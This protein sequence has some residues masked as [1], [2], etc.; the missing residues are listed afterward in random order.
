[1]L[2]QLVLVDDE[3]WILS[4]L[5]NA[6]QWEEIGFCVAGAYTNG[7]DAVRAM[8]E[9]PPDAVLTDIKMP[10]Q[11]GISMVRELREAGLKEMEVVFLSGYD[12]FELA[13]SSVRLGAVDY[14]LKPSAP[15]QI[16]EVFQRIR[17]RLDERRKK[18]V[19][20]RTASE[21]AQAGIKVFKDGV[22]NSI[23]N[24]N[25]Q[26]YSRLM[27]QYSEF[28]ERERGKRFVLASAALESTVEE[29]R[30]D[31]DEAEAICCFQ[32]EAEAL[33]QGYPGEMDILKNQFS[34][35]LCLHD[36][37]REEA[38][39]LAEELR[40]RLRRQTGKK[41]L[42]GLSDC[43]DQLEQIQEA[44]QAS[45]KRLFGLDMA[46]EP[47]ALYLSMGNDTVLKAA[48]E[49]RD[50]QIAMWSLK[51]WFVRIDRMEEG[52]RRRLLGR[53]VYS[54]SIFF[55][56]N[57]F[58]ERAVEQL[59]QAL[60]R[61][62]C[63]EIKEGVISV[64]KAELLPEPG[65]NT[66]N[67]HLCREVAKFISRNYADEITLSGLA[68]QFYISPNYLG[69][70]FRKNMGVGVKEYQA[71]VRL[72]QADV[73][74]SSGKFKLYQ[75]AEMVGYPNYEYFRKTYYK[76]RGKNPSA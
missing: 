51:N 46:A 31:R 45:L 76:Y 69:T 20:S 63:E 7:K 12:D 36:C 21:L 19:E 23:V 9:N 18:A 30:P 3:D 70:L 55:L 53:L 64:I 49:D 48:V 8:L 57:S 34:I 75:V 74:I 67:A 35:S 62:S 40:R 28:V 24:G 65:E 4:G 17:E 59:Y 43:C 52:C 66:R 29:R 37:G 16:I 5:E 13:Q 50:Q 38:R 61:G 58:E 25:R 47:Q 26:A 27:S 39:E 6:I 73:L 60:K 33:K 44:Y 10:I 15:E 56:Q 71:A 22:Y 1:M 42:W 2:Y 11:D 32:R 14:V 72:K 68:D 41:L 54:L